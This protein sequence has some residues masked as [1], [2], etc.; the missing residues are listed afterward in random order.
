MRRIGVLV[1][2]VG[3]PERKRSHAIHADQDEK[4]AFSLCAPRR[5]QTAP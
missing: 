1:R 4:Q 3:M 5:R 2:A